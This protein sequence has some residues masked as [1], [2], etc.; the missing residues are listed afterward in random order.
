M[1]SSQDNIEY[2]PLKNLIG[3][4]AGDNG[5]DIA[6]EPDDIENNPYYETIVYAP[7]GNVDN[8]EEQVLVQIFQLLFYSFVIGCSKLY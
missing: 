3:T 8:A 7:I 1:L 6:P 2:G 4:W 5:I